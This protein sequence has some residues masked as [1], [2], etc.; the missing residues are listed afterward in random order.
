MRN[1]D[2]RNNEEFFS[3]KVLKFLVS[4]L[5]YSFLQTYEKKFVILS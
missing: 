4:D 1:N 3:C 2:Q 5:P